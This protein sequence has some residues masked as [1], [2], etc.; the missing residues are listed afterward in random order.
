[1]GET[2]KCW[3]PSPFRPL[4]TKQL[5][6]EYFYVFSFVCPELGL[7]L[8]LIL[9]YCN[10]KMMELFLTYLS[11]ELCE[12]FIIIQ[13]DRATWHTSLKLK[14]PENIRLI[15]QPRGSP[16][17]NPVEHIWEYIRE[18]DLCNRS[19]NSIKKVEEVISNSLF[20]LTN[21]KE[22]IKSMTNFPHL[23]GYY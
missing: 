23:R 16:E 17:L 14:I 3:C 6:R 4:V 12:Y 20:N 11:D 15:P 8:S 9:P 22:L 5:I 7:I 19:F 18:N 10:M 2:R 1:M 13:V 21:E